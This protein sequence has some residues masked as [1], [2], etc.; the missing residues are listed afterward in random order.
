MGA[1]RAAG[2]VSRQNSRGKIDVIKR[3][4]V[5]CGDLEGANAVSTELAVLV[6]CFD[7]D[8]ERPWI[9]GEAKP[10]RITAFS[11]LA[12]FVYKTGRLPVQISS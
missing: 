1:C 3:E 9:S 5:L 8:I 7:I 2:Y 6:V 4:A 12:R 11:S 10:S